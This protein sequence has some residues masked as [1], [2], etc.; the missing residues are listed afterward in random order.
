[1]AYSQLTTHVSHTMGG[2]RN[3]GWLV[4]L[5]EIHLGDWIIPFAPRNSFVF[6]MPIAPY[7]GVHGAP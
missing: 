3:N 6:K 5:S 1:M 7:E 4:G 2:M